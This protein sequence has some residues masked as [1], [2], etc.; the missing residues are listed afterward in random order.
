M[1]FAP[2]G[3]GP[4]SGDLL[5]SSGDTGTISA[6][7]AGGE[8]TTFATL[9]LP[10]TTQFGQTGLRQMAFAPEGFIPGDNEPLLFVSVSGSGA[11]GGT[12]GDV[13]AVDSRGNV[14]YDLQKDKLNRPAFDP[15]GL[16]FQGTSDLLVSDASDPL[17]I[18]PP[19]AFTKFV[20]AAPEPPA[21]ADCAVVA[22][23]AGGLMLKARK[24]RAA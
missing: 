2:A 21:L 11:G 10:S 1:V 4:F 6:V 22:L 8:V 9:P 20:A 14:V 5:V 3:F 18:L 23:V 15:R 19:A 16:V 7:N 17:V 12:Q 24:R 13:Y